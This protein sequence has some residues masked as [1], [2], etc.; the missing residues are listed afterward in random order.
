VLVGEEPV[1]A[2]VDDDTA[3]LT[4]ADTGVD[5]VDTDDAEVDTDA[6][7]VFLVFLDGG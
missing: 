6:G 1:V 3:T 7:A 5:D 4:D 2:D